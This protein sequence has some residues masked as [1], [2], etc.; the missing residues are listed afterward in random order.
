VFIS[1]ANP[2]INSQ[3]MTLFSSN[4]RLTR[5][6]QLQPLEDLYSTEFETSC[7]DFGRPGPRVEDDKKSNAL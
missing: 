1:R 3:G 5:A 6:R 4:F 2:L 7:V